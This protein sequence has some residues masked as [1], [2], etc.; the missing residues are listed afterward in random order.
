MAPAGLLLISG[1]IGSCL[2]AGTACFAAL[3]PL[4]LYRRGGLSMV[5][6]FAVFVAGLLL[7][8]STPGSACPASARWAPR[9]EP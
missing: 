1:T 2:A 6:A 7:A 3:A 8:R 9:P 5:T 4:P